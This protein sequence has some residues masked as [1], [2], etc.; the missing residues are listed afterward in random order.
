MVHFWRAIV[1][2]TICPKQ[3][4]GKTVSRLWKQ[5]TFEY[6]YL[7]FYKEIAKPYIETVV[8][9]LEF[10]YFDLT[11]LQNILRNTNKE[12]D[13]K[14][15]VLYK[16]L[17]PEH[18]LKLSF[19]NDSNSLDKNFYNRI[20]APYWFNRNQRRRQKTHS[21]PQRRTTPWGFLAR[22]CN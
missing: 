4:I 2:Q 13:T 5:K 17:S 12:D 15:I 7:F 14:L 21:T 20:V 22:K 11:A 16:L 3:G 18:L 10:T 1:R 8:D 6:R 9:K 19:A